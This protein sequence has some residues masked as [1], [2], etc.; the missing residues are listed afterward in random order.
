MIRLA[1][2]QEPPVRVSLAGLL[3]ENVAHASEAEIARRPLVIGNRRSALG[4][5][6]RIESAGDDEALVLEGPC[7][8]F[9]HVGAAMSN[10]SL[11]VVGDIGAYLGLGM[12]AGRVLIEGSAGYG[13]AT[14]MSGGEIWVRGNAGDALGGALPGNRS[15]MRGGLAVVGGSAGA[16]CGDRLRRG[17]II[18]RGDVGPG[19]GTRMLAGTVVV[20]GRAARNAGIAMRRGTIIVLSGAESIAPSFADS[21]VQDLVFIRLLARMLAE[22]GFADLGRRLGPLQCWRGDLAMRGS[23]EL[24]VGC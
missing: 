5:W 22:L 15:G 2:K 10:G 8:R 18:V 3:P 6:F 21:G 23:G 14:A 7:R 20:G 12:K 11:R 24:F 17:S 19:C 9:D 13:I 16:A 1:V 4:E